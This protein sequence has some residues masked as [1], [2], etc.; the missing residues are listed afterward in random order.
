MINADTTAPDIGGGSLHGES[1]GVNDRLAK[2]TNYHRLAEQQ[3]KAS[4][5]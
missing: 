3:A 4:N 2:I 1:P 5:A